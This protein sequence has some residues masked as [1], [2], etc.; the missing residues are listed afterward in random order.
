MLVKAIHKIFFVCRSPTDPATFSRVVLFLEKTDGEIFFFIIQPPTQLF[1]VAISTW[2]NYSW[3]M[4]EKKNV[5][6]DTYS[7]YNISTCKVLHARLHLRIW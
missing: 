2:Q 6:L 1:F 5:I 3:L 7:R 4:N